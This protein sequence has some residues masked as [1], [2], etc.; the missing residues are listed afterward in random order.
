M[1]VQTPYI[2]DAF[3]TATVEGAKAGGQYTDIKAGHDVTID[4]ILVYALQNESGYLVRDRL[5]P[6]YKERGLTQAEL[7]RWLADLDGKEVVVAGAL[8]RVE[9][10]SGTRARRLIAAEVN[11]DQKK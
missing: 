6:A 4:E 1:M 2:S 8:Y 5:F 9:P 11:N 10:A 7:S 3:I